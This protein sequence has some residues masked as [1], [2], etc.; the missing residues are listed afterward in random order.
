MGR[1][2]TTMIKNL[3]KKLLKKYP[4]KFTTDFEHNKKV[5]KELGIFESKKIRNKVA[6][7]IVRLKKRQIL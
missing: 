4:D 5:L 1:I 3:G 2:K 7:Y 6:G